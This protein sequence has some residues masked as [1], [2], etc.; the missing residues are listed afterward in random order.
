MI[1]VLL[2]ATATLLT[3]CGA[4]PDRTPEAAAGIPVD[5]ALSYLK[6][7]VT[8]TVVGNFETISPGKVDY[9]DTI[10]ADGYTGF[11]E[12]AVNTVATRV[13]GRI[14]KL[15]VKYINQR[16]RKG[17]ALM[18]LYSPQ[19]LTA[20]RNLLQAVKDKDTAIIASLRESLYNL[21]MYPQEVEHTVQTGR[22]MVEVTIY[23]PY[24]GIAQDI[25]DGQ[26]SGMDAGNT[27]MT[28]S[29]GAPELLSI[30]EGMYV[31]AGQ[32]AFSIQNIHRVWAIL[33][34]F[35]RDIAAIRV[36][37]RVDLY[38]EAEPSDPVTGQVDLIPPYRTSAE[39]TTRI[40]VYL[41]R[42][43]PNWKI[44]TLLRGVIVPDRHAGGWSVPLSAV[45]RLG[46][47]SVVW[48]QDKVRPNV[49]HA[50]NI[51]IGTQTGDH[52]R[53]ISGL[54]EDDKIV[55]NAAYMVDSDSFIQ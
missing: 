51:V 49:F 22:P 20:Q 36:G 16:V 54:E 42:L 40:R 38:T 9:G 11:D 14:E 7:P 28:R 31:D 12:R 25:T 6:E 43:P 21:G 19:L 33:N 18:K 34:V 2:S 26:S 44:G 37:D 8:R 32:T 45:N 17:Q 24:D 1:L 53:V 52:I 30:H 29:S 4:K 15:F 5:S 10:I 47:G 39:K 35:S 41:D 55:E 27:A 13:G 23:S 3:G 46:A 50:R 48:V